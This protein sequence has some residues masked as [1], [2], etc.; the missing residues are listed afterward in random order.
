MLEVILATAIL[1]ACLIVLGQM[2]FVGTRNAEDAADMTTAQLICRTKLNEI[3][4]GAAPVVAVETQP[5]ADVPG[6]AYSVEV[7][8]LDRFGLVSLRVTAF[9][10]PGELELDSVPPDGTQFTLTRWMRD[11]NSADGDAAGADWLEDSL[12]GL[13]FDEG[14]FQ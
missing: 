13:P 4:V 6:W 9:E 10:D 8:S 11:A 2:A 14:L 5:V 3:L 12:F 1:L 7:E